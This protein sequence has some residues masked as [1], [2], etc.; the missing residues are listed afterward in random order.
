LSDAVPDRVICA[1]LV[2]NEF[3][4]VG[5]E[6]LRE[7]GVESPGVGG[8]VGVGA[9]AGS[10]LLETDTGASVDPPA[11]A[12][13]VTGTVKMSSRQKWRFIVSIFQ[14][15]NGEKSAVRTV[16]PA[17]N[18]LSALMTIFRDGWTCGPQPLING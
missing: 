4:V 1:A 9:G 15:L 6:I 3:P 16:N 10:G 17:T 12:A 2:E 18:I 13:S 14:K 5:W 7:G 11:Q 8:G